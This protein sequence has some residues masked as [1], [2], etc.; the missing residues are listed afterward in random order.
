MRTKLLLSLALTTSLVGSV[1]AADLLTQTVGPVAVHAAN[2]AIDKAFRGKADPAD[3]DAVGQADETSPPSTPRSALQRKEAEYAVRNKAASGK[4]AHD[5]TER[6][7]LIDAAEQERLAKE[8]KAALDK[9]RLAKEADDD[10]AAMAR[11]EEEF[12]RKQDEQR[13]A[14]AEKARVAAESAAEEVRLAAEKAAEVRRVA[15]EER[16]AAEAAAK[17]EADKQAKRL[18]KEKDIEALR[19]Q[20][21]KLNIDN[22]GL[23]K[24][25]ADATQA[26]SDLTGQVATSEAAL[27]A[28]AEKSAQLNKSV[29]ELARAARK[30]DQDAIKRMDEITAATDSLAADEKAPRSV[31]EGFG[32]KLKA[33]ASTRSRSVEPRAPWRAG[34][35]P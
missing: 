35:R 2:E 23:R 12:K 32:T 17:K 33:A 27:K 15:E 16:L 21:D 29:S 22:E 13:T 6:Q 11:A 8:S 14:R 34:S 7:A 24:D 18:Q 20:A 4:A 3:S 26:N 5:E 25:L 19:A 1:Y 30:S 31:R 9:E 28:A 10:E